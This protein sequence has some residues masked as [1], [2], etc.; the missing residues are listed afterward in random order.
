MKTGSLYLGFHTSK[1]LVYRS[2]RAN[3]FGTYPRFTRH[4][5]SCTKLQFGAKRYQP[6]PTKHTTSRWSASVSCSSANCARGMMCRS[7]RQ[8]H[9]AGR[10]PAPSARQNRALCGNSAF[11]TVYFH[12]NIL[13]SARKNAPVSPCGKTGALKFQVYA[14]A[15]LR[16]C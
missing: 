8:P 3:F 5:P 16:W 6:P 9:A 12:A 4:V 1:K 14:T 2:Q 15:S 10:D 7:S 11:V 13:F